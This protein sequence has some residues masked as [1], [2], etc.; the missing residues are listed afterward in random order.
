MINKNEFSTHGTSDVL[1]PV[2]NFAPAIWRRDDVIARGVFASVPD[3]ERKLMRYIRQDNKHAVSFPNQSPHSTRMRAG[4]TETLVWVHRLGRIMHPGMSLNSMKHQIYLMGKALVS[5]PNIRK[6]R[7]GSDNPLRKQALKRHP[8]VDGAIY[9]PYINHTWSMERKLSVIDQ[10][11]RMSSGPASIIAHATFEDIELARLDEEYTGLRFVLDKAEWFVHEGEIVL[12]LFVDDQR[13][14]SI[15]FTLGVDAGQPLV[16]VGALQGVNTAYAKEVYRNIT[17]SLY[18][19][20]PRDL[21]MTVLKQLCWELGIC[22]IWAVS[23]DSRQHNS[24]YYGRSHEGKVRVDYNEVW[25][26]HNGVALDNGFF[27]I[28]TM[29]RHRDMSDIP[30]R[31]RAVYRRRYEML[32]KLALLI[33]TCCVEHSEKSLAVDT[34]I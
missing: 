25:L 31:K 34:T 3:L 14:Y 24:T 1:S 13:L 16:F 10:H 17:H 29:A 33:K 4:V 27:E 7:E 8:L 26:E 21:L 30:T 2:R 20:R 6:W 11:F 12:N 22:R 18:G 15:A 28:P 23:S 9:W 5:L 32:D 19:L